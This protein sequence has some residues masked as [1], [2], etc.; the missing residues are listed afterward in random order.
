MMEETGTAGAKTGEGYFDNKD[1]DFA[2]NL[3]KIGVKVDYLKNPLEQR[4]NFAAWTTDN[5]KKNWRT[6]DPVDKEL[7]LQNFK[8]Q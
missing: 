1:L 6:N 3:G 2:H 8:G 7:L 5:D 4:R